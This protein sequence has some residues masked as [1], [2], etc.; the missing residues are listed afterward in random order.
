LS[1]AAITFQSSASYPILLLG[2]V[3]VPLSLLPGWVE[4]L[5]RLVFLSWS[6]DALRQ[7]TLDPSLD[8]LWT[9]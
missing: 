3:F 4:P 8:G 7:A 6:S 9:R 2:G 1:R 5:G